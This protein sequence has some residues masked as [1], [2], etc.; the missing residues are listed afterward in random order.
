MET[1]EERRRTREE[2]EREWWARVCRSNSKRC[3][4][5]ENGERERKSN[6]KKKR[7]KGGLV[8]GFVWLG[9]A[10]RNGKTGENKFF[11]KEEGK[12]RF[13][14]GRTGQEGMRGGEDRKERQTHS[15]A[16]DG[17][18][19]FLSSICA[20]DVMASCETW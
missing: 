14:K 6:E 3:V 7:E 11:E 10:G 9:V 20:S 5:G 8:A 13:G 4:G 17:K 2:D 19:R 16:S 15:V 12:F 18:F 1:S